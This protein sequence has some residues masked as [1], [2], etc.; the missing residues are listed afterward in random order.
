MKNEEFLFHNFIISGKLTN[1]CNY[2][3]FHIK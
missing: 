2:G 3:L 1:I